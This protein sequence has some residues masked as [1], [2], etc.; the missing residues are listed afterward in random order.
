M[1]FGRRFYW[2]AVK[3]NG[4]SFHWQPNA[5]NCDPRCKPI[6]KIRACRFRAPSFDVQVEGRKNALQGAVMARQH[7]VS[8]NRKSIVGAALI[9]FGL[10]ILLRNVAEAVTL[11][12]SLRI[13]GHEADSLGILTAAE[14]AIRRTLQAYLFNHAEFLRAVHQVLVSFSGLLLIV[15]GTI[16]FA[17]VFEVGEGL[18]KK[19]KACRFLCLSFDA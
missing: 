17:A 6:D 2:K 10:F 8:Q 9:G 1:Q 16:F 12:R 18:K 4:K 13:V 15:T 5:P 7:A 3:P 14:M 19:N 11:I